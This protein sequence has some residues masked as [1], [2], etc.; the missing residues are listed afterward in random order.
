MENNLHN[1]FY[2][3]TYVCKHRSTN[4]LHYNNDVINISPIDY[5]NKIYDKERKGGNYY[6]SFVL[7]NIFEIS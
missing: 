1:R 7:I 3:I 5:I 4:N 6:D 2:L